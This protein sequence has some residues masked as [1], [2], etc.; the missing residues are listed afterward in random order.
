M[1][2]HG[3]VVVHAVWRDWLPTTLTGD[4]LR[5]LLGA[6]DWQRLHFMADPQA[7]DRFVASRLLLKHTVGA[8]LQTPPDAVELTSKAG[9][10][11]YVRGCD[12]IDVSLSHTEDLLVVG[13]NRCGRIGVDTERGDRRIQYS[14]VERQLCT[15]AERRRLFALSEEAQQHDLVRTWV[16]KEAYTKA[17]GQGMRMGFAQFGFDLDQLAL[18]TPQGAP[19]SHGEWSF[20]TF[21]LDG[22]Y[23][24]GVACHDAGHGG[25]GDTAISTMLD[26]G[27]LGEV[28]DRVGRASH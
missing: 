24:V 13:L 14:A 25:E 28:V 17:L 2:W 5:P 27:F 6:R 20:G 26:E 19:A 11:P 9:G 23:V 7:R 1:A 12:Q 18:L 15:P 16:L 8:V 4:R 21:E 10:R 22:G 3:H